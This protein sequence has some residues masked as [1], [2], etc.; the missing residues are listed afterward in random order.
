MH[1]ETQVGGRCSEEATEPPGKTEAV[2]KEGATRT[3]HLASRREPGRRGGV[4]IEETLLLCFLSAVNSVFYIKLE[5]G[6]DWKDCIFVC[7]KL[8]DN[9]NP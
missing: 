3:W 1:L 4:W 7:I 8:G 2:G 6:I 9:Y 5:G